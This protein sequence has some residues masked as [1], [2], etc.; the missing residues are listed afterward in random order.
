ML[1]CLKLPVDFLKEGTQTAGTD[2]VEQIP[3]LR[4]TRNPFHAEQALG[5]VP[6]LAFFHV[7]LVHQKAGRLEKNTPN[8]P[9]PASTISY[10][11]LFPLRC[12][13]TLSR[14]RTRPASIL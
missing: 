9:S 2:R 8:A 7:P 10:Y 11:V 12:S 4:I 6:S 13:G 5:I 1:A 14:L 3:D